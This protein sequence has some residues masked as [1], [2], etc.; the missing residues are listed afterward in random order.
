MALNVTYAAWALIFS[1]I[2][3]LA[4]GEDPSGL[5]SWITI[6]CT[7]VVLVFGILAGAD[8][9]DLFRKKTE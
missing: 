4:K 8:Y 5:L 7:V 2:L 3:T 1:V 6:L 9:K